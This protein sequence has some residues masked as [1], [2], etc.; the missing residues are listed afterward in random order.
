MSNNRQRTRNTTYAAIRR[1]KF[2]RLRKD[3]REAAKGV[4]KTFAEC[5]KIFG[6][7]VAACNRAM[8]ELE[9]FK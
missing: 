7:F 6:H 4:Q 5:L 1:K 3:I 9:N 8:S 2:A